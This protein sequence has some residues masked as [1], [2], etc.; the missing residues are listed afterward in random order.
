MRRSETQKP[1]CVCTLVVALES[2]REMFHALLPRLPQMGVII[3][4]DDEHLA[5]K[6]VRRMRVD[7]ALFGIP[8]PHSRG[9]AVVRQ[10]LRMQPGI[11]V[12]IITAID[13]PLFLLEALR[14][15]V[16]GYLS[17]ADSVDH[18]AD[19]LQHIIAGETLF[20]ATLSTSALLRLTA[21]GVSQDAPVTP[22]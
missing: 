6:Y 14:I 9:L 22:S 21:P 8:L 10:A 17:A 16:N 15:G 20:D 19:A 13:D 7:L 5:L 12:V 4:T 3:E 18:L 2:H 11:R 1:N